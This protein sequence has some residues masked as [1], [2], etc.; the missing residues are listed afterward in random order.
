MTSLEIKENLDFFA[1][2]EFFGVKL[3][4]D[5]TR[6]LFHRL[7]DPQKNLR[8]IHAAGSNGKGS[9][10]A[11]LESALRRAGFRT[12]F[13][14]SPHLV[15]PGERFK[16]NAVSTPPELLAEAIARIRPAIRAME[17]E[18]KKVTYFEAATAIA[19]LIFAGAKTDFVLWETG[20]GGR[21]D[22]TSIVQPAVCIITGISLEHTARLGKTLEKIAFE[23]AGIIKE[24]VPVFCQGT[25][26]AAA[27]KVI[28]TRAEELHAPCVFSE[29]PDDSF[30]PEIRL[31]AD[32][33]AACQTFRLADG[34]MLST[35]L[36]GIHQRANAALARKVLD[37][38]AESAGFDAVKAAEGFS[39]VRWDGRFQI[40]PEKNLLLDSAHNPEGILALAQSLR[41]VFPGE[42]FHFLFG[43]F[44]DKDT[45][46]SLAILAPLA[47][48]FRWIHL[49]DTARASRTPAEL[50]AELA[51][52]EPGISSGGISL[53]QAMEEIPPDG[54][55]R[56]LC[57]S[58]HLCG[59]ALALAGYSPV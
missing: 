34:E 12:G 14:S 17:Q 3:G 35:A 41:E 57:G 59:Q 46:S 6:E 39:S 11:L 10:C 49:D 27:K 36:L 47:L 51:A 55:M 44:S 26:P 50:A 43:A 24:N 37:F 40:F 32:G 56:I 42:K 8:F 2:L 13:Y 21:L 4:L 38:L 5:Q 18:G 20:M 53:A 16:I 1:S 23:K 9:V 28:Q 15:H 29:P 7:G 33:K 31:S 54:A 22:A 58:L 19:A 52:I 45:R 25:I 48:S 30:L